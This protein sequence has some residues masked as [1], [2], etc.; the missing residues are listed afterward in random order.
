VNDDCCGRICVR[1][2]VIN[3]G[4]LKSSEENVTERFLNQE[5]R[6]HSLRSLPAA[7]SL[8]VTELNPVPVGITHWGCV[9]LISVDGRTMFSVICS[10]LYM[11][12]ETLAPVFANV[13]I[14]GRGRCCKGLFH[15][16]SFRNSE[17]DVWGHALY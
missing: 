9:R 15:P 12:W 8:E 13:S 7:T 16:C 3:Q 10:N 4:Q 17:S 14:L 6:S 2:T 1:Q 11:C 5:T